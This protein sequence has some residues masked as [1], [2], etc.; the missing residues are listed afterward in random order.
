M[1]SLVNLT[2]NQSEIFENKT[3]I[4]RTQ[5]GTRKVLIRN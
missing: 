5:N 2:S 3:S 4:N 1:F